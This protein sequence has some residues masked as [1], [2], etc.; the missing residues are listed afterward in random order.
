PTH[1][2]PAPPPRFPTRRSSDLPERAKSTALP[3]GLTRGPFSTRQA[4]RVVHGSSPW[5]ARW[6]SDAK[7]AGPSAVTHANARRRHRPSG[8]GDRKSTRL[9]SSHVK[10]SYAVF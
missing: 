7:Q 4:R 5:T 2:Q 1:H 8:P 3:T 6:V 9:N 10:T